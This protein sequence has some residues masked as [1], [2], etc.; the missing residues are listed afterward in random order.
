MLCLMVASD[1]LVQH[2]VANFLK[3]DVTAHM[4]IIFAAATP[5]ESR[6]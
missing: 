1:L 2:V 3:K 6:D 4:I 5:T